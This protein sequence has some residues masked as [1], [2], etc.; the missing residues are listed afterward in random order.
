M[1]F[2]TRQLNKSNINC[3]RNILS[4]ADYNTELSAIYPN[5]AYSNLML[6]YKSLFEI[7]CPGKTTKLNKINKY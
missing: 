3:F 7:T 2:Q 6:I 1:V 4:R 5:E